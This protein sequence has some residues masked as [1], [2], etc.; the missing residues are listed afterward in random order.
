MQRVYS[1][2]GVTMGQRIVLDEELAEAIQRH[3]APL[4]DA[5]TASIARLRKIPLAI[6]SPHID[7]Q[8]QYWKDAKAALKWSNALAR[9][10]ARI[11]PNVKRESI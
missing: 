10:R 6:R 3:H 9:Q 11:K 4:I 2:F 8:I 5:C 7:K 1:V